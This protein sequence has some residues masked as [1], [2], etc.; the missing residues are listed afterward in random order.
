M[1]FLEWKGFNC[2][3]KFVPKGPI[4]NIPALAHITASLVLQTHEFNELQQISCDDVASWPGICHH[5]LSGERWCLVIIICNNSSL[6]IKRR[7]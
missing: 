2:F 6:L 5:D 3:T 4:K 7:P 1:N